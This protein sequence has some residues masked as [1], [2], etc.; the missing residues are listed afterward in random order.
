MENIVGNLDV[1][2]EIAKGIAAIV[3]AIVAAI[4]YIKSLK[5]EKRNIEQ[6]NKNTKDVAITKEGI[7]QAFKS[8]IVS[9]DVK[10]SINTQVE[11]IMDRKF[12]DLLIEI[13]RDNENKTQM[14]YWCLKILEW[15]AAANKL[16]PEQRS[17]LVNLMNQISKEE[18]IID[19][20]E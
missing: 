16:T 2:I 18:C 1:F 14:V 6:I 12:E 11:R 13:K 9:K 7:V 10:V 20:C 8:S 19:T 15:T 5:S 3:G 17:E 4:M